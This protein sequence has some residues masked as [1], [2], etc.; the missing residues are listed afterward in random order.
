MRSRYFRGTTQKSSLAEVTSS[1]TYALNHLLLT[2]RYNA[3]FNPGYV[4]DGEL[5]YRLDEVAYDWLKTNGWFAHKGLAEECIVF[6]I[7]RKSAT[8]LRRG[9][10][11]SGHN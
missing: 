3:G 5:A 7:A 6:P 10:R 1:L 4:L 2:D 11:Q 8:S 9:L